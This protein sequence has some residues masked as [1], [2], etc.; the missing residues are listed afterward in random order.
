M[1]HRRYVGE[2]AGFQDYLF[3]FGIRYAML[4]GA[5]AARSLI[6]GSNYD[7]LCRNWIR[8]Q[9]RTSLVNRYW[10]ECL[11]RSGYDMLVRTSGLARDPKEFWTKI[12]TKAFLRMVAYPFALRS[13]RLA[14]NR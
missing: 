8:A 6:E 12:Y 3:G 2:A 7:T 13:T 5:L 4:S 14:R 9:H 10:Y 1:G 11:G